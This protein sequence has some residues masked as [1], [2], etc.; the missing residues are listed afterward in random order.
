MGDQSSW[1]TTTTADITLIVTTI[2]IM[3][4]GLIGITTGIITEKR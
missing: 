1:H 3:R 4:I 2:D